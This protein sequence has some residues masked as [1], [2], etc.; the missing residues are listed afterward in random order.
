M[1]SRP[2]ALKRI[3]K[4]HYVECLMRGHCSCRS[5]CVHRILFIWHTTYFVCDIALQ[6]VVIQSKY[7][8]MSITPT[9]NLKRYSGIYFSFVIVFT[10]TQSVHTGSAQVTLNNYINHFDIAARRIEKSPEKTSTN[11]SFH[12]H[13]TGTNIAIIIASTL[14]MI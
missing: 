14:W 9:P 2:Q 1:F 6:G 8:I 5:K 13:I 11:G 10:R 7:T 4:E 3:Q 12:S